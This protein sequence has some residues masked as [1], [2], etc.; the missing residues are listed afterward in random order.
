MTKTK[1]NTCIS[2][3][4]LSACMLFHTNA[5]A[6]ISKDDRVIYEK[7]FEVTG[8]ENQ[9]NQMLSI[10][11]S[12]FKQ[13]FGAAIKQN[14]ANLEE[15]RPEQKESFV[16]IMDNAMSSYLERISSYMKS[17]MPFNELVEN[18][19]IPVYSKH[20][21]TN[22]IEDISKFFDSSLGRKFVSNSPKLMQESVLIFNNNYAGKLQEKSI[23]IAEEEFSKIKPEVE[24]LMAE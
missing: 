3:V 2:S 10:I 12:Q 9:Y 11:L 21:G 5:I 14:I 23:K 4:I 18:V 19:Y 1:L 16:K 6:E 24:K 8:A 15:I 13:G 20:F 17:E 22:E 7:F